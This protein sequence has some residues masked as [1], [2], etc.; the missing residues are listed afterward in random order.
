MAVEWKASLNFPS[1]YR[2]FVPHFFVCSFVYF[3]VFICSSS[4]VPYVN[5]TDLVKHYSEE[6]EEEN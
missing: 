4:V 6:E 1:H 2:G 3:T 5:I